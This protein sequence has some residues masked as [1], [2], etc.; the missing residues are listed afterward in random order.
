VAV[1][2]SEHHR[3]ARADGHAVDGERSD[4]RDHLRGVVVAAR[5]RARDHDHQVRSRGRRPHRLSDLLGRVGRDLEPVRLA[6]RRFGLG[7][8]HHAVRVG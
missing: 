1:D 5:A 3:V 8:E 6:A 4:R 7:S 2:D